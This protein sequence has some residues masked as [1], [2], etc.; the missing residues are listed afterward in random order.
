MYAIVATGGKQYKVQVGDVFSV[1]KIDAELGDLVALD[2]IFVADGSNV[3]TE[4]DKLSVAKVHTQ[5]VEHYKGEKALIF[6]FKKRK[7]YKKLRGHRQ[8]L[9]KLEVVSIALDGV[10]P[11]LAKKADIKTTD[12][13]AK[14]SAKASA[15]AALNKETV[16]DIKAVEAKEAAEDNKTTEA[17]D[18]K[19]KR[20]PAAKKTEEPSESVD[21]EELAEASESV[22]NEELAEANI[23]ET[24]DG[25]EDGA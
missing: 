25:V 13:P 20:K 8:L 16:E 1:E 18:D 2:V 9:T 12:K 14:D 22:D 24:K 7:G 23:S 3:I 15:E 10:A 17:F 21:S 19:P 5:V 4:A 11:K 6:K